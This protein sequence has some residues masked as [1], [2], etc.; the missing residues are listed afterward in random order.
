[1]RFFIRWRDRR[2]ARR[3]AI[4]RIAREALAALAAFEA[5]RAEERDPVD[6]RFEETH[7]ALLGLIPAAPLCPPALRRWKETE[8]ALSADHQFTSAVAEA[9][10]DSQT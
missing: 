1:M 8:A 7:Q 5:A 6:I 4:D 3:E 2:R 10:R 9:M